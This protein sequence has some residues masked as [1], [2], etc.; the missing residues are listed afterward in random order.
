MELEQKGNYWKQDIK[1]GRAEYKWV[2]VSQSAASSLTS[3]NSSEREKRILQ[4]LQSNER[5]EPP[6]SKKWEPLCGPEMSAEAIRNLQRD[7]KKDELKRA[8]KQLREQERVIQEEISPKETG[9]A[10]MVAK[11]TERRELRKGREV[12]PE[13]DDAT[14]LGGGD[15]YQL[16]L[17]RFKSEQEQ[18]QKKRARASA[19]PTLA[20]RV[21]ERQ[22]K[23]DETMEY[24]KNIVRTGFIP[25]RDQPQPK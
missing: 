21:E 8:R 6:P 11:R 22:K 13:Y 4:A 20:Q 18:R 1:S 5:D 19:D 15:E 12:S 17:R 2:G 24:F 23:E 3:Q 9:R 14:L 10:A 16:A 25:L 7:Q